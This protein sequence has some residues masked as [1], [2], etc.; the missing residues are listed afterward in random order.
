[1]FLVN[2]EPCTLPL[3]R[4]FPRPQHLVTSHLEKWPRN[5]DKFRAPSVYSWRYVGN[6]KEYGENMKKYV[7]NM[8]KYVRNMKKCFTNS[9]KYVGSMKEC[10]EQIMMWWD[11]CGKWE[12]IVYCG[13]WTLYPNLKDPEAPFH[14]S[15]QGARRQQSVV[16]H[17]II[18][19]PFLP[20]GHGMIEGS[21]PLSCHRKI[22]TSP[23]I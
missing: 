14:T 15:L 18:Q 5:S 12:D 17:E 21:S 19:S 7:G 10:L 2:C 9:K 8:M 23:L 4:K 6:I 22:P 16:G 11:L 20:V 3:M 13:P 1:M